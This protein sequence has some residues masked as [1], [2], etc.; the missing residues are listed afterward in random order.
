MPILSTWP[1]KQN[2]PPSSLESTR[3]RSRSGCEPAVPLGSWPARSPASDWG[4]LCVLVL[5]EGSVTDPPGPAFHH[6]QGL[7]PALS[8]SSLSPLSPPA[9]LRLLH[10]SFSSPRQLGSLPSLPLLPGG[11]QDLSEMGDFKH[12]FSPSL[13]PTHLW[14]A[15]CCELFSSPEECCSGKH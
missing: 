3:I 10:L 2:K 15:D 5:A 7:K 9:F 8:L 1:V 13:H 14:L 12:V 11:A 4:W 6:G